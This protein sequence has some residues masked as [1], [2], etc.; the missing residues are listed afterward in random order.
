[1]R[2][3]KRITKKVPL[4]TAIPVSVR[5]IGQWRHT[6]PEKLVFR[7]VRERKRQN[8]TVRL[9]AFPLRGVEYDVERQVKRDGLPFKPSKFKVR[10]DRPQSSTE[11]ITINLEVFCESWKLSYKPDVEYS[12]AVL[13]SKLRQKTLRC[14]ECWYSRICSQ[15]CRDKSDLNN[16]YC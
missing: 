5:F 10:K 12:S 9:R 7:I 8:T 16:W 13:T 6:I 4:S 2:V 11:S 15:L 14:W 1:M 3:K